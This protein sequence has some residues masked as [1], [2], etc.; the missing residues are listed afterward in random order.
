MA[1]TQLEEELYQLINPNSAE[2]KEK[3]ERYVSLVRISRNLEKSIRK[4]GVM[5]EVVNNGHTYLKPHPGIAEKIKINTA[6]I[7]LGEFFDKKRE[8]N[9]KKSDFGE[10]D[11][12]D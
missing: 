1:K 4:E 2:E 9:V 3:V 10:A 8:E 7:K 6:L 11:L 5:L 12:Y